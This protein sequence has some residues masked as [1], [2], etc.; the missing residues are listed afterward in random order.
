MANAEFA[1][2]LAEQKATNTILRAAFRDQLEAIANEILE[3][4]ASSSAIALLATGQETAGGLA[5]GVAAATG[6]KGSAISERL[7]TLVE[8]GVI[9][10]E[11]G[12]PS[13]SYRLGSLLTAGQVARIR[14]SDKS[15]GDKTRGTG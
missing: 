14:A 12:G 4:K 11:G 2:L 5:K 6:L 8:D 13:T 7:A 10:R 9:V 3:D 15:K 1:A